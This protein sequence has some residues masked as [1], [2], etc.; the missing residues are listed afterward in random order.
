MN[1]HRW[2]SVKRTKPD[3]SDCRINRCRMGI[4]FMINERPT[5]NMIQTFFVLFFP[6]LFFILMQ[7]GWGR[8]EGWWWWGGGRGV[9]VS[10]FCLEPDECFP[11]ACERTKRS[12]ALI[13]PLDT[14]R[15]RSHLWL[16]YVRGTK[17]STRCQKQTWLLLA[18]G[19]PEWL[20]VNTKMPKYRQVS[21][22]CI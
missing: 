15:Y 21:P 5:T 17:W 14:H 2:S 7:G 13:G 22:C 18:V 11:L 3:S 4:E 12:H 8:G 20:Q 10:W 16:A 1:L 6:F 9:L 19:A